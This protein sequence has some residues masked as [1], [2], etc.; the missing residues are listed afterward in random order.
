MQDWPLTWVWVF[1][2]YTWNSGAGSHSTAKLLSLPGDTSIFGNTL[3]TC[4]SKMPLDMVLDQADW[5]VG[6]S[7]SPPAKKEPERLLTDNEV[8]VA[9]ERAGEFQGKNI[10]VGLMGVVICQDSG[11]G[12]RR[13]CTAFTALGHLQKSATT[14]THQQAQ[15]ALLSGHTMND[16]GWEV[17]YRPA[18]QQNLQEQLRK[19]HSC[20]CAEPAWRT[21][22]HFKE[23]NLDLWDTPIFLEGGSSAGVFPLNGRQW[24]FLNSFF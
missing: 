8:E 7:L 12:Y 10:P 2:Y 19:R 9:W 15:T 21:A 18:Q 23:V 3:I 22:V 24:P 13:G 5:N 17:L 1:L 11:S 20:C 16:R 14:S 6:K 4:P